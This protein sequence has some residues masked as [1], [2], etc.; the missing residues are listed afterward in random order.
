M[1]RKR[2]LA[3]ALAVLLALPLSLTGV[4]SSVKAENKNNERYYYNQLNADAKGIYDAMYKMYEKGIFK[5]GEQG[6]DLVA[7]GHITSEQLAAYNEKTILSVFGAARDAFYADYPDIFY[8][9]FSSLSISVTEKPAPDSSVSDNDAMVYGASLGTGRA[10]TYFTQG[11]TS[12]SAVE[13][14]IKAHESRIS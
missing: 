9:D 2:L 11:F 10:D 7:N 13:D 4:G 8:V 12:Q 6:Y 1:R 14:A 5:T 3:A